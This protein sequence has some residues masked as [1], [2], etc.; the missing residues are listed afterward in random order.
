MTI[1]QDRNAITALLQDMTHAW[2]TGEY[3]GLVRL[4]HP[5]MVIAAPGLFEDRVVGR[6][7]CIQTYRDF[8]ERAR[9]TDYHEEE[10]WIGIWGPTATASYSWVMAWDD[11]DGAS[12]A[13]GRDVLALNKGED[14]WRIVGRLMIE[15]TLTKP[16]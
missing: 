10:P 13:A 11:E 8:G 5:H 3:E 7:A 6:E 12:A 15:E 2:R 4:F 9:I 1:E 14:G 16:A